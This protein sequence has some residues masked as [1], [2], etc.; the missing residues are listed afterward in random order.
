MAANM[1][2]PTD[3][4]VKVTPRFRDPRDG[5]FVC[6][7]C[8]TERDQDWLDRLR[9]KPLPLACSYC[10]SVWGNR[11]SGLPGVTHADRI[12]LQTLSAFVNAIQWEGIHGSR[13]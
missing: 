6:S 11:P 5:R 4:E 3:Y 8:R 10:V 7:L 13:R 12:A 1:D 2:C 9:G